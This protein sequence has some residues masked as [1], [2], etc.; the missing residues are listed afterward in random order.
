MSSQP[1]PPLRAVVQTL[2]RHYGRPAAPRRMDP[3]ELILWENVAYLADDKRRAAAFTLLTTQIGSRP[4]QILAAPL[5]AL[6]AV[7]SHGILPDRFAE[8]LREI[9]RIAR[10]EFDGDLDAVL[11]LPLAKAKKALRKFPGIGEPGAEKILLFSRRQPLLAPES[12]GLRVLNRLG[13]SPERK[14]YA[15]TYVA[16]RE[17][18]AGQIGEDYDALIAAHSLLRRHGQELCRRSDPACGVCPLAGECRF[19]RQRRVEGRL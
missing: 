6:R 19:A 2:E 1:P 15:A 7:T 10:D 14:S 17:V 3:L 16:A 12:N 9:A 8:K 11:R 13:I 4:E 18:T 5:G